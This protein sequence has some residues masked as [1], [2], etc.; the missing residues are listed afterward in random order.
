MPHAADPD[1]FSY[2]DGSLETIRRAGHDDILVRCLGRTCWHSY[3]LRLD[4]LIARYGPSY[5]VLWVAKRLKCQICKHAGAH[6][7]WNSLAPAAMGLG[8]ADVI[9]RRL[10][11]PLAELLAAAE[12]LAAEADGPLPVS[13]AGEARLIDPPVGLCEALDDYR[14][15][16]RRWQAVLARD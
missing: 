10:A 7:A 1:H 13:F 11:Q 16:L 3:T 14:A 9:P 5:Q 6:V 12:R 4:D 8:M 15:A 2:G